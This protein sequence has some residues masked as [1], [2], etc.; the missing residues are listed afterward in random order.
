MGETFLRGARH[1]SEARTGVSGRRGRGCW[2]PHMGLS[3]RARQDSEDQPGLEA[4]HFL[5]AG[6]SLFSPP[7]KLFKGDLPFQVVDELRAEPRH[8][9]GVRICSPR[10]RDRGPKE[11]CLADAHPRRGAESR[12]PASSGESGPACAAA[13]ALG[14]RGSA[15]LGRAPLGGAFLRPAP[16]GRLAQT[17]CLLLRR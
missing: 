9:C 6:F 8:V 13:A 10:N 11:R 12:N 17:S 14:F 5:L 1:R 4:P 16:D 7:F 15:R 2:V 3:V